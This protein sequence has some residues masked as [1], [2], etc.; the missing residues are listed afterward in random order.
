MLSV[1]ITLGEECDELRSLVQWLRLEDDLRGR[2]HPT[3]RPIEPGQMGG[4]LDAII[5]AVSSGGAIVVL[6]QSLFTWL[7]KRRT[8]EI[9]LRVTRED[10]REVE[11]SFNGSHDIE[12]VTGKLIEF[13]DGEKSV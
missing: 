3:R 5:V 11:L 12:A 4:A 7:T 10:G 6:V 9:Y 13:I 2:I 1:G 8:T